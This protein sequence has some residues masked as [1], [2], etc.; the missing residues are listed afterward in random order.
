[1]RPRL[2]GREQAPAFRS[3]ANPR[4]P[5]NFGVRRL[6]AALSP[7]ELAATSERLTGLISI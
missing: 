5:A 2:S 6:D 1:M 4:S 3:N 7:R